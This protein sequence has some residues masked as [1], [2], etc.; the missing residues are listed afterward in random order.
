MDRKLQQIR[1]FSKVFEQ[2]E[3]GGSRGEGGRRRGWAVRQRKGKRW[4]LVIYNSVEK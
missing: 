2:G 1:A 4:E 3:N